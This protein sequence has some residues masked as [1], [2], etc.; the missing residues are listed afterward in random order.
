[1][2]NASFKK[3]HVVHIMN[4]CSMNLIQTF[5][6][7]HFA[8]VIWVLYAFC[9]MNTA[10]TLL[11]VFC[12]LYCREACDFW[13][14]H[15]VGCQYAIPNIALSSSNF[16]QCFYWK[17]KNLSALYKISIFYTIVPK[18]WFYWTFLG[19]FVNGLI[20]ACFMS[21]NFNRASNQLSCAQLW[22][23]CCLEKIWL[24][25]ASK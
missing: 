21:N 3:K 16:Q 11:F 14:S 23:D 2:R 12:L 13:C 5:L 6:V 24:L 9:L 22:L 1:M 10:D 18:I 4:M 17:K 7:F 19:M 8:I 20:S 15:S 25:H